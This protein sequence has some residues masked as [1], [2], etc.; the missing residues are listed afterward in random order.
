M[1]DLALRTAPRQAMVWPALIWLVLLGGTIALGMQHM[2]VV[3]ICILDA[4]G[5]Y[6]SLG[7]INVQGFERMHGVIDRFVF[8][9]GIN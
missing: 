7:N 2:R 9:Q 3:H 8:V 4:L 6:L 1:T 5:V